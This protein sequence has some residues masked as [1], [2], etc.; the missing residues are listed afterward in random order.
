M[1]SLTTKIFT[2]PHGVVA[3]CTIGNAVGIT[4]M[5]YTT[6]G[7]FLIPLTTEFGWSR[8]SISLVLLIV[9]V[10][11]AACYPIIGRLIDRYGARHI[12]LAGNLLFAT[13]LAS[14]SLIDGSLWQLYLAYAGVGIFAAIPSTVMFSK[15][16]A[17]WFDRNRGLFLGIA[18]GL[19]NGAG[20]ALTPILALVLLGNY[21][22]RGGYLG[23]ALTILLIG[24]PALLL[25][26]WNPPKATPNDQNQTGKTSQGMTLAESIRTGT[27]WIIL[28]AIGLGAGCMTAIFAHMVPMLIDRGL[29]ASQATTV[30]VTF[31]MVTAGWQIGVGYLL[32]RIPKAWVA[33]PFYLIALAG[34]ILLG[35]TDDYRLL[36][37]AGAL[38]GFGLGTEYG[39]L[40]YFLSRYFGVKHYGA[41]SGLVY[42][43]IVLTQGGMPVLMALVFDMTGTYNIATTL[44]GLG[45]ICGAA[46]ILKLKPFRFV[47]PQ[48]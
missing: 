12:M 18:G 26:L 39:V 20:A 42:G 30:L 14:V 37:L 1:S 45:L 22:W 46:L 4:P 41:I 8:S 3:A 32:D 10:A 28:V 21:G 35:A 24:F 6:W 5:V 38:L 48:D 13:S 44:T 43:L 17:G 40:P 47:A 2:R 27:F 33:A 25:W 16:I 36:I 23:L 29:A 15:V 7:L 11:S 34:L 9:A 19:G 31:S